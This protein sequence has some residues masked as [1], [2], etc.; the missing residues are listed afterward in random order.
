MR[1][2][3]YCTAASYD[4]PRLQQELQKRVPSQLNRD[5]IHSQV[6]ED[7]RVK[8]DAFYFAY[9]VVILWGFTA[10]EEQ[11]LLRFLKD[12]EKEPHPRPEIDEFTFVYGEA[13]K[14]EEDEIILQNK[15]PQ[16]KLA[17]SYG[18]AQSV[19]LTIFEEMIQKTIDHTKHL[20]SSLAKH[21]KIALTRKEISQKM[22]EIFIER[23]FINLHS[24]I[25]D[26]PEFFWNHP[27]LE[28]FY[29]RTA[30][31]LDVTK[32]VELLNKRLNVVHEL[33]EVLTSELNH[34][35]SSRL[36]WAIIGLIIVE[37]ILTILKDIF[38]FI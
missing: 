10:D 2:T 26:T 6:R 8:G 29:R 11:E 14:I 30:H 1:C 17:I 33:F 19:K 13:M 36:E 35:H 21:G 32:R 27:E 7:K 22:G 24:E 38:H 28:P 25:L 34:Q 9:G 20:P 3:G 12:F 18:I 16:T 31:Y 37:V 5:V 23:N 4:M 15:S